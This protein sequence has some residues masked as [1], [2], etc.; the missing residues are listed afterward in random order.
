MLSG[1]KKYQTAEWNGLSVC[2]TD[3][4]DGGGHVFADDYIHLFY[5]LK[6]QFNIGRIYEWCCGPAFIGYALLAHH[7]GTSLCL[8]DI[9]PPAIQAVKD[10]AK[11]NKIEDRV[12]VYQG[13]GVSALPEHEKFDVV[14]GNPPQFP[15]RIMLEY[16][17]ARDPK[18]NP[19][20]YIDPEWSLHKKFFQGIREHMTQNGLVVLTEASGGSHVE[21]FRPLIEEAGLVLEGW[22]W[23]KRGRDMYYLFIRRNDTTTAFNY[24]VEPPEHH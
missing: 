5:S 23:P 7:F 8:S 11:I 24:P 18:I 21:T 6:G 9:Y 1:S 3:E 15:N 20:I 4:L 2:Y 22:K 17:Y 13:D 10:T 14:V 16:L 19:R 12:N